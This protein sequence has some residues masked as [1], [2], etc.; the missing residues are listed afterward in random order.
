MTGMPTCSL[1]LVIALEFTVGGFLYQ[2]PICLAFETTDPQGRVDQGNGKRNGI[3]ECLVEGHEG[4]LFLFT[5][6]LFAWPL[7]GGS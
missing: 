4:L 5:A 2:N 6:H 7:S 1:S 3:V